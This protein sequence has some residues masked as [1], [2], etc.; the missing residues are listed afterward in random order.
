MVDAIT[1][2]HI[3]PPRLTKQDCVAGG[4]AAVTVAGGVVLR[5]RLHFHNHAPQALA[6]RLAFHQQAADEL[7]CH[8][9]GEPAKKDWRRCWEGVVAMWVAL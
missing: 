9:L 6:I 1:H 3:R 2:N 8:H 5:I 7:G 4:A